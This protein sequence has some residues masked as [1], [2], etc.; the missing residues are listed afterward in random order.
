MIPG[1]PM[2]PSHSGKLQ[3]VAQYTASCNGFV[4]PTTESVVVDGTEFSNES[5]SD[6][7]GAP[8]SLVSLML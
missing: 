8:S 5:C 6:S 2:T 1:E 7:V 4:V 3:D